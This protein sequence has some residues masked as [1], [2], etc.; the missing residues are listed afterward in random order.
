M[1]NQVMSH[2]TSNK[3]KEKRKK[4]SLDRTC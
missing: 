2:K 4:K 3:K 1:L